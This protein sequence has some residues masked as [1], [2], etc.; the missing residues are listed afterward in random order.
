MALQAADRKHD[1]RPGR[2]ES[3]D[4]LPE[5]FKL[6]GAE[7]PSDVYWLLILCFAWFLLAAVIAFSSH[8][9]G[10]D[11]GM[12]VLIFTVILGLPVILR[13]ANPMFGREQHRGWKDFHKE[14]LE[15]A[16]GRLRGEE[17]AI[18]VLLIPAALALAAT[19]ISGVYIYVG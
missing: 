12:S 19:L 17:A 15:I 6:T 13:W 5:Q 2:D 9:S 4:G 18:Q 14:P 10:L 16:T 7:F 11:L 8:A 3:G 1:A